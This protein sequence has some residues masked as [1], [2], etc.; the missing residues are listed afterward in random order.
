MSK[1]DTVEVRSDEIQIR[2][3]ANW[4]IARDRIIIR[5]FGNE[6]QIRSKVNGR[7]QWFLWADLD[8]AAKVERAAKNHDSISIEVSQA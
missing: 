1:Y 6:A 2:D 7:S 4:I 3:G 5:L 8:M